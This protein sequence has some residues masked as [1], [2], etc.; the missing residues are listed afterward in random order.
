MNS[1]LST[2]SASMTP[3]ISE[4]LH[5]LQDRINSFEPEKISVSKKAI[6]EA[7]IRI[8]TSDGYAAVTIRSLARAVDLKPPTIYSHFEDGKDQIV[9]EALRLHIHKYGGAVL[10]AFQHC[11]TPKSYW[12]ALVRL[13][14]SQIITFQ[15][16]EM[17]DLFMNMERINHVLG[18][19]VHTQ[20]MS[21]N[22]F[23]DSTFQ[24]IALD[25][26]FTCTMIKARSI[27]QLLDSSARWWQWDGTD[28]NL[29]TACDY[30]N[31]LAL[32]ILAMHE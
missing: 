21:W 8:A 22:D 31:K 27:R 3:F 14:I 7:F 6:L 28:E 18:D 2:I 10:D 19:D 25:L 26:G 23:Y 29:L 5:Q 12:D 15:E 1:K 16:N 17:W 9:S 11:N 20:V 4:M 32:A 24:S 13:H 30:G